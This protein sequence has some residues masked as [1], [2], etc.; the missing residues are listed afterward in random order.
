MIGLL[1]GAAGT[2][3]GLNFNA[4]QPYMGEHMMLRGFAVIII[5]G[6]GDPAARETRLAQLRA[7]LDRAT[8]G[9]DEDLV[10]AIVRITALRGRRRCW[11]AS[12]G[13]WRRSGCW[14]WPGSRRARS[15][16]VSCT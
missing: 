4:I 2:L 11:P 10:R 16:G 13:G 1:A 8:I 15:C 14:R 5:G 3:I 7:E 12:T 6:L 9:T